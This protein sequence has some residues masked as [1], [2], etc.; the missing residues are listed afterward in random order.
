MDPFQLFGP[1]L[2]HTWNLGLCKNILKI[3]TNKLSLMRSNLIKIVELSLNDCSWNDL[4]EKVTGRALLHHSSSFVGKKIRA[5]I[6]VLPLV[7]RSLRYEDG[8]AGLDLE[9]M[10]LSLRSA[11]MM[12]LVYR[13]PFSSSELFKTTMLQPLNTLSETRL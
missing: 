12:R 5:F 7:L 3:I 9:I 2:L 13:R 8:A 6:L 10:G 11:R 4:P 1:E